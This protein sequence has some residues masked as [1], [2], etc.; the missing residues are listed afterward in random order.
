MDDNFINSIRQK[1]K[2]IHPLIF[3]RSLEKS[4]RGSDLFEILQTMP[5]SPFYWDD[6]NKKWCRCLDFICKEKAK[7]IL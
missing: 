4:E 7:S 2:K 1:Y 3:H 6:S 5:R